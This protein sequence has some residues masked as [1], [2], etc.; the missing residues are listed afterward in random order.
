VGIVISCNSTPEQDVMSSLNGEISDLKNATIFIVSEFDCYECVGKIESVV[1]D[2][3]NNEQHTFYGLYYK[4]SNKTSKLE[5]SLY[6]T[7]RIIWKNVNSI[8][9]F[10]DINTLTG[11]ANGPYVIEVRNGKL[12]YASAL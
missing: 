9:L 2:F 6:E 11:S 8:K 1:N 5:S 7:I 4:T 12:E 10:N 3:Q